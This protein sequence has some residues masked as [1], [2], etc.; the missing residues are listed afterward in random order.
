MNME[1]LAGRLGSLPQT[2]DQILPALHVV[3]EELGWVSREAIKLVARQLRVTEAQVYGPATFY[4]EFRQAPPP[5]TL[6]AWCS[7]P[8]CRV[9]GG[10]RVRG[11]LEAELG[12]RMGENSADDAYGLWLGQ[13]NGTCE[14]APMIWVNG[15]VLGPLTAAETVRLCRKIKRGEAV[16]AHPQDA[17]QITPAVFVDAER[18]YG[19]GDNGPADESRM[20]HPGAGA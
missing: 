6:V 16:I 20:D 17:V 9:V 2:Q 19:R 14:R 7:G 4:A 1:R 3:Q 11:I 13:C 5:R 12:C 18:V 8:S 15:R 10:D